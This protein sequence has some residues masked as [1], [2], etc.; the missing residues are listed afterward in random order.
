MLLIQTQ[1]MRGELLHQ[2]AAIDQLLREN[3]F[4]ASMTA[5]MPAALMSFYALT[6]VREMLRM[7]RSRR[8]SRRS[9][10]KQVRSGL[11]DVERLLIRNLHAPR[12]RL[13]D[14]ETGFLVISLY[15]L[16]AALDR[17]RVLFA[18]G[19]RAALIED[20]ADLESERASIEQ[21]LHT[22]SRIMRTH[23]DV[24]L[25]GAPRLRGR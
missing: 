22:C 11:R 13:P 4:T 17:H 21:K 18:P 1:Y 5:L 24:S 8:R 10:V 16:R 3:A 7:L 20:M 6:A 9:L 12:G 25:A 15:T 14:E 19:E 2:M 23:N